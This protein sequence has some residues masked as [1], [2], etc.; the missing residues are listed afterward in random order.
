VRTPEI[1]RK[2]LEEC[3]EKMRGGESTW[4]RYRRSVI[5]SYREIVPE[6]E[7]LRR[8]SAELLAQIQAAKIP[9]PHTYR[10]QRASD[11]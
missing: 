11:E 9:K 3:L 2:V 1:E 10:L 5:E 8:R 7:S 4:S 6:K